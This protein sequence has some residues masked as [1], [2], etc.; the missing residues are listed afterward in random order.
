[1]WIFHDTHTYPDRVI[2]I[3]GNRDINKMRWTSELDK[4]EIEN[5]ASVPGPYWVKKGA[6][7]AKIKQEIKVWLNIRLEARVSPKEYLEKKVAESGNKKTIVELNTIATRIQW[8]LEATMGSAGDFE[9]RRQELAILQKKKS[10]PSINC[11]F[12]SFS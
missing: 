10:M 8:M 6:Y 9:R 11:C 12:K 7:F 3:L 2:I 4:V 5:Y 1:M